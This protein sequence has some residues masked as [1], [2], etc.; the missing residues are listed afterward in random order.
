VIIDTGL[1]TIYCEI[2][3]V[4][5]DLD[6]ALYS[7]SK[8]EFEEEDKMKVAK[9]K[10]FWKRIQLKR[11]FD[12][13]WNY[14]KKHHVKI[15]STYPKWDAESAKE[16]KLY[17][18]K[19]YTKLE[20]SDIKIVSEKNKANYAMNPTTNG[21]NIL[22]DA[23]LDSIAQWTAAGGI[24]IFHYNTMSTIIQLRNLGFR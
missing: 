6:G 24:G 21:P 13:I 11:D 5:S 23:N 7:V 20:F 12:V 1:T 2:D 17:W 14:I 9:N 15:I 16:G 22:I 19:K 4:L 8:R 18:A 3:N 10:F